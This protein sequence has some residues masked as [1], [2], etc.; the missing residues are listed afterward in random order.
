MATAI[1]IVRL[2]ISDPNPPPTGSDAS[3]SFFSDADIQVFLDEAA[4]DTDEAAALALESMAANYAQQA[5][6]VSTSGQITHDTTKIPDELRKLAAHYRSVAE[7]AP[8]S[9][10]V[11]NPVYPW[12]TNQSLDEST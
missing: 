12:T 1:E 5:V 2:K 3:S 7:Q 9:A 4:N 8:Y 6:R 10:V 11:E